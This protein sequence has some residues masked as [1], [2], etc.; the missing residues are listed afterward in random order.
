MITETHQYGYRPTH[1]TGGRKEIKHKHE[2]QRRAFWDSVVMGETISS[3]DM[4]EGILHSMLSRERL[5][6][7]RKASEV[8]AEKGSACNLP[9]RDCV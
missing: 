8:S 2:N 9:T 6:R 3:S 5:S 4:P 7:E 1:L